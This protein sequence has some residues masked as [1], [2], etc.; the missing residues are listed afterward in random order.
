MESYKKTK[1]AMMEMKL[2]ITDALTNA[3]N[4]LVETA[5]SRMEN[6]AMTETK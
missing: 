5:S 1:N 2:M 3:Q 6:N 4:L